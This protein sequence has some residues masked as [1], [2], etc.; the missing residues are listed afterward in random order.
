VRR[1]SGHPYECAVEVRGR[2][3]AEYNCADVILHHTRKGAADPGDPETLRGASSI[4]GAARVVLT[5]NVMT[6]EEAESFGIDEKHR[7]DYFRLDGAKS[8]YAP[9]EDAEWFLREIIE[10]PNGGDTVAVAWP[11][12]PP[13]TIPAATNADLNACLDVIAEPAAGWLYAPTKVSANSRRWACSVL[14]DK[15][16]CTEV[17]AKMVIGKWLRDGVLYTETYR[18]DAQREDRTG[19]RVNN[20]KRPM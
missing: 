17:Q 9:I 10:L 16:G 2:L 11:W 14:I 20:D 6:K 15:L 5:V 13:S 19:V 3:A 8:N 18:N 1:R 12:V 7:R 4:V